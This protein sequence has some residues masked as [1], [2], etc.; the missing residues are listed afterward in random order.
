MNVYG[1][2][3][4]RLEQIACGACVVPWREIKALAQAELDRRNHAVEPTEKVE[5]AKSCAN[6]GNGPPKSDA[7]MKEPC[8]GGFDEC[9]GNWIPNPPEWAE[10]EPLPV[11][12]HDLTITAELESM[13]LKINELINAVNAVERRGK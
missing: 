5:A 3:D 9:F 10:I 7:C 8:N 1:I 6:C 13:R 2:T 12:H 4:E 11:P